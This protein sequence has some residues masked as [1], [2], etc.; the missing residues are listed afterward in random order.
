MARRD[1]HT[2]AGGGAAV[3]EAPRGERSG[4]AL[5]SRG[6]AFPAGFATSPWEMMRRMTED[7]TDLFDSFGIGTGTATVPARARVPSAE[8]GASMF[9]TW[10]PR[11]EL[12]QRPGEL[13]VRADLPG[14][15]VKDIDVTV[16]NGMLIISG[17]RSQEKKEESDAVVRTEL[18][19]G[20]FYRAIPLPQGADESGVAAVMRN[21]TL[22]VVVPVSKRDR[23]H[24]VE[25]QKAE[26]QSQ[27]QGRT[28]G[29]RS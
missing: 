5:V 24:R 28:Q 14:M 29:S 1:K 6:G 26:G 17:E 4:T 2:E 23:G 12:E 20:R 16:E 19:Y 10:A 22:E 18:V 15:D 9:A 13:V 3:Q 8:T 11:V 7:L 21:G 27:G 25:V